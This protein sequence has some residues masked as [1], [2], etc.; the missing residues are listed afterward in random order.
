MKR[1]HTIL[2]VGGIL[3]GASAAILLPT[4]YSLPNL[5]ESVSMDVSARD[6]VGFFLDVNR[7]V[8]REFLTS[9]DYELWISLF[10]I[11]VGIVLVVNGI[12]VLIGGTVVLAFDTKR[13]QLK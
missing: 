1:A 4:L 11:M 13:G 5:I 6:L 3:L 2:L 10:L 9:I 12:I 7:T 8:I